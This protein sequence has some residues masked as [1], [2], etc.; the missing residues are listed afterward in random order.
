MGAGRA[1]R[2]GVA[3][4]LDVHG[5]EVELAVAAHGGAYLGWR[6]V[7]TSAQDGLEAG[8]VMSMTVFGSTVVSAVGARPPVTR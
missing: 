2:T 8:T 1:K 6:R 3:V 5:V 4:G 7:L